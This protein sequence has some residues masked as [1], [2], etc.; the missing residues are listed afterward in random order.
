MQKNFSMSKLKSKLPS[1]T[2]INTVREE[3]I[4][5]FLISRN[6]W[7]LVSFPQKYISNKKPI[8]P[9]NLKTFSAIKIAA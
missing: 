7:F 1:S 6:F 4:I 8:L 5:Q 2:I 9:Q 3:I